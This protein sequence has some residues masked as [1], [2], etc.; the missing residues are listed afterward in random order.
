[1]SSFEIYGLSQKTVSHREPAKK[2]AVNKFKRPFV[3]T[4]DSDR[5]LA[6]P[7]STKLAIQEPSLHRKEECRVLHLLI[8]EFA[9]FDI[10][11][12]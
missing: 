9:K 1:M 2:V 8:Q 7:T 10:W 12:I 11:T 6:Y 4:T 3:R 5:F